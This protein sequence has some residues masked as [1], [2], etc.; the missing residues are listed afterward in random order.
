MDTL[1]NDYQNIEHRMNARVN[2]KQTFPKRVDTCR[3]V[4]QQKFEVR[5]SQEKEKSVCIRF[6]TE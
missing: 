2:N 1:T 5:S 3:R 4:H 6:L